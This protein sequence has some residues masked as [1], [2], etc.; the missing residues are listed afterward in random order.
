LVEE[1]GF[2]ITLVE[3]NEENIKIT[4]QLDLKIA[5]ITVLKNGNF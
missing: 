1:A 5:E 4:T 3:G 2:P